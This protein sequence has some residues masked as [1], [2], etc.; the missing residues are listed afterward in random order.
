MPLTEAGRRR[1]S[2]LAKAR[3]R[4]PS[5][6]FLP[7]GSK[8]VYDM[9]YI[10]VGSSHRT[11]SGQKWTHVRVTQYS[12]KRFKKEDFR[13]IADR[14]R[15]EKAPDYVIPRGNR[16]KFEAFQDLRYSR[17]QARLEGLADEKPHVEVYTG[18]G[19]GLRNT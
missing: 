3:E 16:E 9:S 18:K 12:A 11:P 4:T 6:R 1:L 10:K 7:V 15:A 5:G 14:A 19:G 17:K 2:E 13:V 8:Y